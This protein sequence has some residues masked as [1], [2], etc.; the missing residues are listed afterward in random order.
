MVKLQYEKTRPVARQDSS[1]EIALVNQ[2]KN[3]NEV[4]KTL[5]KILT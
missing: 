4:K 3:N 1:P 2:I 5:R